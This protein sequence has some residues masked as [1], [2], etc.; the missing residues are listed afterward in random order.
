L[1][2]PGAGDGADVQTQGK[3][4]TRVQKPYRRSRVYECTVGVN[5]EQTSLFVCLVIGDW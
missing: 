5:E 2:I 3:S 4:P 1:G